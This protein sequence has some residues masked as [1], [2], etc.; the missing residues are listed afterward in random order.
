MPVPTRSMTSIIASSAAPPSFQA[1]SATEAADTILT[2][3]R[4]FPFEARPKAPKRRVGILGCIGHGNRVGGAT[5]V[6]PAR[7][8]IVWQSH[9]QP[10]ERRDLACDLRQ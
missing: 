2:I 8:N 4:H 9:T 3:L 1:R 5:R 7:S 10:D 6:V